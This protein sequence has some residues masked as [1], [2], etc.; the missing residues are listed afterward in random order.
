MS[1]ERIAHGV[2]L[3][4]K[5]A[6]IE[7]LVRN[8]PP[9]KATSILL[10]LDGSLGSTHRIEVVAG[11]KGIGTTEGVGATMYLVCARFDADAGDRPRFPTEFRFG[12]DLR[13]EFLDG[14]NGQERSRIA[15]DGRGIGDAQTH[16][17]LIVGNAVHDVTGIFRANPVGS[18]RPRTA[19][20]I[21]G[22]SGTQ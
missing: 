8:D 13:V 19:A 5:G 7:E 3:P 18:L 1:G 20:G 6:E 21:N 15:K 12:I 17:G 11:V 10:Q 4:F 2:H 9:S 16:E 14:I 22:S